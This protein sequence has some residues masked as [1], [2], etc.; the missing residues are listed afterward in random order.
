MTQCSRDVILSCAREIFGCHGN[1]IN[2][3]HL[4]S[5]EGRLEEKY[6]RGRRA[7]R[8]ATNNHSCYTT[9]SDMLAYLSIQWPTLNY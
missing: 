2:L 7:I 6:R 5:S 8:Y 9:V 1:Q 3:C 4:H